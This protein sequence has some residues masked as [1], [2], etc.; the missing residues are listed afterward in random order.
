VPEA[1][2]SATRSIFEIA[3]TFALIVCILWTPRPLQGWLSLAALMWILGSTILVGENRDAV[4]LGISGLRRSLWVIVTALALA[5]VEI[6][7]AQHEQTLHPPYV[8]GEVH[9]RVWGYVIWSFLQQ[10]IL[11][12]YFLLRFLRVVPKPWIAV[13][14]SATL[15]S[16]AHIPNPVLTVATLVWGLVSC[17]LFLRYSDLY[18]LGFAHAVFGLTIAISVPAAVH[19]NMRVGLGYLRYHPHRPHVQRSQIPHKVS[20]VAWVIADAARRRSERQA[21]P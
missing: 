14:G 17:S 9:Y 6:A 20:T 19:H 7:V 21:R 1:V 2:R 18:S 12:D 11:Q 4:E 10:F 15:F 5:G 8:H 13:V 16:L 3:F